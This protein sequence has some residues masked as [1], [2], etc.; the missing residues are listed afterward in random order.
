MMSVREHAKPGRNFLLSDSICDTGIYQIPIILCC[1]VPLNFVMF[2]HEY[3]GAA[4][5]LVFD[6]TA[7]YLN[8]SQ[9]TVST[10]CVHLKSLEMRG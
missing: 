9:T 7:N 3:T 8:L 6:Y 5:S 2:A 4:R 10:N 1:A